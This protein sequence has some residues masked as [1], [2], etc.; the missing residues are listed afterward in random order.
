MCYILVVWEQPVPRVIE[1]VA[2]LLRTLRAD[3]AMVSSACVDE[4]MALLWE[5]YPR[6]LD[7]EDNDY[8][9]DDSF[10]FAPQRR[11]R[12]IYL[13][14]SFSHIDEVMQLVL[15]VAREKGLVVYDS[16]A[17]SSTPHVCFR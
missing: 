8:V 5:K 2:P 4:F 12:L 3:D 15:T 13:N 6:D 14:I 9:W 17:G 11:P 7:G 1:D 16:E 10:P